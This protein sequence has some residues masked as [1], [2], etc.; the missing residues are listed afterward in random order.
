VS[1][2]LTELLNEAEWRRCK[3]SGPNDFEACSYFLETYWKIRHPEHGAILFDMRDAQRTTLDAWLEERLSI[4]LKARQIG[5]STLVIGMAFWIVFF[6]ED[7][8]V[9]ALS[10]TE[11]EAKKLLFKGLYGYKRLPQWMLDRGPQELSKTQTKIEFTNGSSIECFPASDPARGESAFLI[12]VDEWAFFED[13][14]GA[15][16]AIEPAADI[17]GRIIALSTANGVG[18]L[19]HEMV[20]GAQ[21]GSNDF[22]FIFHSWRAVPER[23]DAWYASKKRSMQ[24]ATLHQEYPSTPEEAFIKSGNPVFDIEL[25]DSLETQPPRWRG[26]LEQTPAVSFYDAH[27][28]PLQVWERPEFGQRYVLGAD[29]AE[30]LEHGDYSVAHVI[31]V[32]TG[33]VVAK[34]RGHT[35][36]DKFGKHVIYNLGMWYGK[37]F[38]GVESN[39]HGYATLVA[40]RDAGY[41]NIYHRTSYDE[42]YNKRQLKM[43]WRTQVNTKPLAID[44]LSQALRE[45]DLILLDKETIGELRTFRRVQ[46]GEGTVKMQGQPFDDQT[47]SLAIANMMLHHVGEGNWAAKPA[48]RWDTWKGVMESRSVARRDEPLRIGG[49]N[50]R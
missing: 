15:W 26:F 7:K 35:P 22:T 3:G 43:G 41:P 1:S 21:T 30:G 9:I 20:V 45:F 49:A 13:P 36:P 47:M 32:D 24:E 29:V 46:V 28:G 39:N 42:S 4:V 38:A 10:K 14:E 16:S 40:L 5:F 12:I 44:Y 27:D 6:H 19:Y 37:A 33:K 50:R 34:W 48:P 8:F 23:D 31:R 2:D 17:G 11:R 25:L 18:N